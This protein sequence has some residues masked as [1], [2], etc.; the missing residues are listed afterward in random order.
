MHEYTWS[1]CTEYLR[2]TTAA[3][4]FLLLPFRL[5]LPLPSPSRFLSPPPPSPS[6]YIYG[7]Y[8]YFDIYG[9]VAAR[10]ANCFENTPLIV[11]G[12]FNVS[13]YLYL[14]LFS[15]IVQIYTKILNG[16]PTS[17]PNVQRPIRA[18]K[19]QEIFYRV[20]LIQISFDFYFLF[21]SIFYIFYVLFFLFF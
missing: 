14:L 12:D 19:M 1:Y 8:I 11:A 10:S 4:L 15:L 17:L 7:K 3:A 20:N 18:S 13:L 9:I 21:F 2:V 5:L 6:L 16:R